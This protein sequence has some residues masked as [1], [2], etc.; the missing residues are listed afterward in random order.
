MVV[1]KVSGCGII[2]TRA[3]TSAFSLGGLAAVRL[4]DRAGHL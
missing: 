1:L 4:R 3:H 2:K